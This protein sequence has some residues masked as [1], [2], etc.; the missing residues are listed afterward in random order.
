MPQ[1][2]RPPLD[3]PPLGTAP[4]VKPRAA[5]RILATARELFYRQ[6]IRAVG[7]DEIV[8]RSG[9]TKPSLYRSFTS[10]D[11][12]AAAY[13]RD[14]DADF[15]RRFEAAIA[16]APAGEPRAQLLTFLRG[17]GERAQ[18]PAY[19]GCG[20]TNAAI[21]YP[22]PDNPARRVAILNKQELRRRLREFAAAMGAVDPE[23]LGDGLLLLVE[24][25][26]VSGQLF[27]EGGPARSLAAA[28]DRLIEASLPR[29]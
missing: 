8:S 12:L 11:E 23:T 25:A 5:E 1:T 9:V 24:G 28:A 26:Y 3:N 18:R 10:K 2:P 19:R 17:V 20:M 4:A 6:G 13:M 16:L 15:W 14:Y 21:E 27:G 7:V 29:D 22:E